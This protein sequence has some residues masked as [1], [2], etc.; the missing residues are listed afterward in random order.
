MARQCLTDFCI[1]WSWSLWLGPGGTTCSLGSPLRHRSWLDCWQRWGL[2]ELCCCCCRGAK[3]PRRRLRIVCKGASSYDCACCQKLVS[4]NVLKEHY[5]Q[6]VLGKLLI[7][8]YSLQSDVVWVMKAKQ[9]TCSAPH[10][11]PGHLGFLAGSLPR[12]LLALRLAHE[13]MLQ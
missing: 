13:R 8:L 4:V 11:A 5:V 12:L 3:L 6:P 1:G 9:T 2:A 10:P 7:D